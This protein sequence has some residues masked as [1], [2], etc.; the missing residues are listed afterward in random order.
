MD[1][2]RASEADVEIEGTEPYIV[3]GHTASGFWVDTGRGTT[4][5]GL[6]AAGDVAGGS[7]KKYVTGAMAEASIAS[8]SIERY[9][10]NSADDPDDE[11]EV[12]RQFLKLDEE[13]YGYVSEK[14]SLFGVDDLEEAMQK[15]MDTYAGGIGSNYQYCEKSLETAKEK[16]SN[17]EKL[18][19]E[20]YAA[21]MH[22]LMQI[23][24]I[25]ERLVVC[26]TLIAHMEAR[27]ETRWHSF[28]ENQDHP[29]ADDR[30]WLKYVNTRL[31]NGEINVI[32]RDL[33]R[34][35]EYYEHKDR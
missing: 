25:R 15:V 12:E 22:E 30:H 3:G 5:K 10:K 13:L 1:K 2:V 16:I 21:D 17:L 20:L 29:N 18:L 6:Y 23:Y 26:K 14:Q 24:E 27:K 32:F 35:D 19:P 33:V 9:L 4:V 7:P 34:R 31:E 8:E 28:G 11:K